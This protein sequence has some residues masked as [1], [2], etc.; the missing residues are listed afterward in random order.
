VSQ[1]KTLCFSPPCL[2]WWWVRSGKPYLIV[3]RIIGREFKARGEG[4]QEEDI[5]FSFGFLI[6]SVIVQ[7]S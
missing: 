3:S 1:K 4:I 6:T 2:D 7:P 5:L